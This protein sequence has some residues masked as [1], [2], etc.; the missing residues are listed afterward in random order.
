M[1]KQEFKKINQQIYDK[2]PIMKNFFLPTYASSTIGGQSETFGTN[3]RSF[4]C[5]CKCLRF[6]MMS[7]Y[8]SYVRSLSRCQSRRWF[9]FRNASKTSF[10]IDALLSVVAFGNVFSA[11]VNIQKIQSGRWF[12][13][14][15]TDNFKAQNPNLTHHHK[16]L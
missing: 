3:Q 7:E 8:G 5:C 11:L 15:I 4:R 2:F 12:G 6:I 14:K 16:V 10:F 9:L 13:K 1:L